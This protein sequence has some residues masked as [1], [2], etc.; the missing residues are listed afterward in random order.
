MGAL[1]SARG[2]TEARVPEEERGSQTTTGKAP[3]KRTKKTIA[4]GIGRSLL[5]RERGGVLP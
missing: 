5:K 3:F 1:S 4:S 2:A